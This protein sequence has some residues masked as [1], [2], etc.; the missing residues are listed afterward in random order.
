MSLPRRSF[1]KNTGLLALAPLV[2]SRAFSSD[3]SARVVV[4]GGGFGGVSCA[5]I[6]K[7]IAPSNEVS[8][9]APGNTYYA[10]PFSNL[11]IAGERSLKDQQ[12]DYAATER[13]GIKHVPLQ[14][15][16][17]DTTAQKVSLE[18]GATLE[19]DRLILSP[20]IEL[21]F[22]AL[23]GY[24]ARAAEIMPHAWIAGPQT[25]LLA[26]QLRDM[27][28]GGLFAMSIPANPYRCPPGP[29]ERASL[30]AHYLSKH[31]PRAKILLLDSKDAFSKKALFQQAWKEN[32]GD[33]IQWQGVSDGARVVSVEPQSRTLQ[34]DFDRVTADVANVIP[35]QRAAL[36]ARRAG[37]TDASG[38]CPINTL[39]FESSL[40]PNV[41]VIGDAAIANAMPKS[42]FAANAQAKLCAVQ[43]ARLLAGESPVSTKL[44]N[45]CY[46]LI[47]P[48]YAISVAAVYTSD[49][50]HLV[51]V[52]GAGGVSPLD[53][54][55]SVRNKEASYAKHW[56]NT[57]TS[58]VFG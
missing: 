55:A 47:N 57:I 36:I 22:E 24:D 2:S 21:N 50:E 13:N 1:L 46:S 54:P 38:W 31:N 56:F 14:A 4:I 58:E 10:C 34:T 32:Y 39:T 40:A 18:G 8:L 45:T 28:K 29:Y 11:V 42:A 35:P 30:A 19:Y 17:V 49:A 25:E 6:L 48:E 41:H 43:V 53:A 37:V 16:D 15:I 44:I 23:P 5:R 27:P 51:E 7:R 3:S 52:E 33:M 20:G 12:F 9:I 26:K